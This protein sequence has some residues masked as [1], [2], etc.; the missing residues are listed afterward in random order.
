[1]EKAKDLLNETEK[2]NSFAFA[3]VNCRMCL[4]LDDKYHY[5]ETEEDLLQI[6]CP[7]NADKC[8]VISDSEWHV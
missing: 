3:D 4:K 1:M 2:R 5:F 6:L 7:T 8:E